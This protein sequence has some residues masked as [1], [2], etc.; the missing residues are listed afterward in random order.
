M[1]NQTSGRNNVP[2]PSADSGQ[3]LRQRA[4]QR[5]DTIAGEDLDALSPEQVRQLVH[6]LQVHQ[7]ELEMQNEELLRT[8]TLLAASQERYFDL[9]DLAPVGYLTLDAH[10]L[11]L[12]VNLTAAT[13]LETPRGDLV[14]QPFTRFIARED[15]DVFYKHRKLLFD[16]GAPQMC[17]MRV[18]RQDGTQFWAQLEASVRQNAEGVDVCRVTFSDTTERKQLERALQD[19]YARYYS[20]F[21]DSPI[22]LWVEDFSAVKSFLD[23]VRAQGITDFRR[24]FDTHPASVRACA[25]LVKVIDVN[26]AAVQMYE[27]EGKEAL[28]SSLSPVFTEATYAVFCDELVLI[29]EGR[30]L[31]DLDST[32]QTLRGRRLNTI[33]RW[34]VAPGYEDTLERVYVSIIDITERKRA[35]AALAQAA[36]AWQTT[37]DATN[38]AIWTVDRDQCIVRANNT[39]A[40][41]FQRPGEVLAGK[42][43][44]EVVH[45]TSGPIPECPVVLAE[46]SLHREV[47]ELQVDQSWF[48]VTADPIL[49]ASGTYTGAVHIVSDI[50]ERKKAEEALQES[51]ER[52]RQLADNVGIAFWLGTFG[53]VDRGQILYVNPAFE[54]IFGIKPESIY[55]SDSHWVDILY[56]E[57]RE[58]ALNAMEMFIQHGE[59]Y[60]VEYRIVGSDGAI[61]WIWAR[62]FPVTDEQGQVVRTAGLAYDITERKKAEEALQDSEEKFRLI[63]ETIPDA[64]SITRLSDGRYIEVNEGFLNMTGHQRADV[65]GKTV[66]DTGI[67]PEPGDREDF[68]ER[69]RREGVLKGLELKC[70]YADGNI[71]TVLQS[72]CLLTVNGEV[73]ILTAGKDIQDRIDAET[74]QRRQTDIL[75]TIL[76]HIPVMIAYRD[77]Q[78][79]I[80]WVN[81]HYTQTLGLSHEGMKRQGNG[82]PTLPR[83]GL[84]PVCR[85]LHR[86]G[87]RDVG[88]LQNDGPGWA[89]GRYIVGERPAAGWRQHRDW[90]GYHRA[91]ANGSGASGQ[92][93]AV[94]CH[95]GAVAVGNRHLCARRDAPRSKSSFHRSV[96]LAPRRSRRFART[97]QCAKG[98][99]AGR[100]GLC[101][102]GGEG[103]CR[104]DGCYPAIRNQHPRMLDEVGL[105]SEATKKPWT[106]TYY[107]P[108]TDADGNLRNV[109]LIAEDIT[110]H[111]RAETE[112]QQLLEQ[113]QRYADELEQRVADRTRELTALYD[114]ASVANQNLDLTA[115]LDHTLRYALQAMRCRA[116]GIH[117]AGN[118]LPSSDASP[119]G[120]PG[121][122]VV[123]QQG[124][125]DDLVARRDT[126]LPGSG[127]IGLA[128][129][130]R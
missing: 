67:W 82:W 104:G 46:H 103:I 114:I 64:L 125:P 20:L 74:A 12:E 98:T 59:A 68:V 92:R 54:R 73:C 36:Q 117:L 95:D 80:E 35:E 24:Y 31:F 33:I 108:L 39:A 42:H 69:L 94:P 30:R 62:G 27:A 127:L 71:R 78:G 56:A 10:G 50:T 106:Q 28:L 14:Q 7:I 19:S 109:V 66:A 112:R 81:A 110:E 47:M 13:M 86:G 124:F 113:V 100:S 111:V 25:T 129:A 77:P 37:F 61:R 58:R 21:Q 48:R 76:D 75:Q 38:D 53:T 97:I 72:N 89:R 63:F 17:E 34:Y 107:Y 11:I 116:G 87:G 9:F 128:L 44:W 16:T 65:I 130:A 121:M 5:L 3:T 49:D 90:P 4:E 29:A 102:S 60:D 85:R 57:D 105:P 99:L 119:T 88:R 18:K 41:M 123:V 51:E 26:D 55:A 115:T 32:A 6:E 120:E 96:R 122:R 40:R 22:A 8:Q 45:G 79:Q 118:R 126:V 1:K 91:Q 83:P 52:F 70:R 93:S 84:S 15:Q 101:A 43:C 23:N 2:D